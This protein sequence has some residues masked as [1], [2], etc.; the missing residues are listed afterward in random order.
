MTNVFEC[1]LF[2]FPPP[3]N[4]DHHD[5]E[6]FIFSY[7][8]P[9]N[10]RLPLLHLHCKS[11][12]PHQ[13][14]EISRQ[15]TLRTYYPHLS[16]FC[17]WWDMFHTPLNLCQKPLLDEILIPTNAIP[18]HSCDLTP[19]VP[20]LRAPQRCVS[21]QLRREFASGARLRKPSHFGEG[22]G[23]TTGRGEVV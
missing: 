13:D 23:T 7:G 15:T 20:L 16:T 14:R 4:S 2:G 9:I 11:F 10:H 6:A 1:I 5:H 12:A 17:F 8:I 3:K 18:F 21:L 22:G 19:M